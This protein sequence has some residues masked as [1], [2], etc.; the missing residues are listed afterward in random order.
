MMPTVE[1]CH[2]SQDPTVDTGRSMTREDRIFVI[3]RPYFSLRQRYTVY[4]GV[5]S[6]L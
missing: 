3:P 5:K 6:V 2:V 4:A 1:A